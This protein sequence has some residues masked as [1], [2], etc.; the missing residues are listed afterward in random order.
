MVQLM[1]LGFVGGL[2]DKLFKS[3]PLDFFP[4]FLLGQIQIQME[5]DKSMFKRG[6]KSSL[7][8]KKFNFLAS[9]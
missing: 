2:S 1:G 7:Y 8:F 5:N 9:I 6:K 3:Q 4:N